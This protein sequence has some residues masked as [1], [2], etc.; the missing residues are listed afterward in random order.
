MKFRKKE[1][2][3]KVERRKEKDGRMPNV[4]M[5]G[6]SKMKPKRKVDRQTNRQALTKKEKKERKIIYDVGMERE[7][8]E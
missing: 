3:K 7:L 6:E 1:E 8:Y 4:R 5:R 2:K